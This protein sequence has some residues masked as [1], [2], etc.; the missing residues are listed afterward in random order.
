MT[1][2][3]WTTGQA[4]LT[5][6]HCACC[7][8][9]WYFRRE[10]CPCCGNPE[11]ERLVASGRG[12]VYAATTVSRAPSAE[13]RAAA[14]YRIVLVDAAEGFRM[15]AHAAADLAIGDPVR[16]RFVRFGTGTVPFCERGGDGA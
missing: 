8:A 16:T 11:P 15:M 9:T 7:G 14:P 2:G 10:F 13:L 4:A 3:D 1:A 6:G 12:H 5:Y